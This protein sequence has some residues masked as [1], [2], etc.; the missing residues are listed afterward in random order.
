MDYLPGSNAVEAEEKL[1]AMSRIAK[2]LKR[3]G[4]LLC[5]AANSSILLDFPQWQM[6]MVRVG[7]LL[8]GI[9]PI[10]PATF[11][12]VPLLLVA[13]ALLAS[14]LPALRASRVD[15]VLALHTE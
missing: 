3:R 8:Y 1:R 13:V 10:D 11:L 14:L 4:P 2:R 12:G 7:N 9:N 5:H 6:D 15:P